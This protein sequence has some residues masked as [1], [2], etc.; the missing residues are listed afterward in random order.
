MAEAKIV[1][2]SSWTKGVV[3]VS[4]RF[5]IPKGALP[6][7]VN[8]LL[9]ER[10]ALQVCDGSLRVSHVATPTGAWL[11][12]DRYTDFS[13]VTTKVGIM[14]VDATHVA[15]YDF[16]ADPAVI[17]VTTTPGSAS[18]M[19]NTSGWL[20]PQAFEF[21][22][23]LILTRGNGQKPQLFTSTGAGTFSDPADL[24]ATNAWQANHLYFYGDVVTDVANTHAF[25]C[26]GQF[27]GYIPNGGAGVAVG[28]IGPQGQ[29]AGLSGGSEP[30]WNFATGGGTFDNV[31]LWQTMANVARANNQA[32]IGAA[33][34]I[35]HLGA[36]WAWNTSPTNSSDGL[37]GPCVLRQSSVQNPNSWPMINVDYVGRDDGTSGTGMAVFTIAEAGIAP[38]ASL[39]LFKDYSTYQ[40]NGLFQTPGFSIQQAKTNMGCTAPRSALFA[41]GYGIFRLTHLGVAQFDGVK[42]TI[43]S[44]EIRPYLFGG[45][46]VAGMDQ[47]ND[48]NCRAALCVSPPLYLLAIPLASGTTN[49]YGIQGGDGALIRILCYDL[50]FKAWAV[51]DLPFKILSLNQLLIQGAT[52]PHHAVTT[53]AGGFSDGVIRNLQN[54]DT[55]FDN[56][57]APG[58]PTAIAWQ[59]ETPTIGSPTERNYFRRLNLRMHAP[60]A[61]TITIAPI[62]D[63]EAPPSITKGMSAAEPSQSGTYGTNIETVAQYEG[64]ADL[65]ATHSLDQNASSARAQISGSGKTTIEAVQWQ[66]RPKPPRPSA[67]Q[68]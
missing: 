66:V 54:G 30:P 36:L 57:L 37:D 56:P 65:M 6:L 23:D 10:G 28:P 5:S 2:Q 47:S 39:V 42:D 68:I 67:T 22:G 41:T 34:M 33:H 24:G 48:Q 38:Q 40:V 29:P 62:F 53:V 9:G 32:P 16:T 44:E 55:T 13:L 31:L 64:E 20:H 8:L 52:A 59:M 63:A 43:I 61:P 26:Y 4:N 21:A 17:L 25:L 35:Q 15:V 45:F 27:N 50:I 49:Y 58:S 7:L 1:T 19:S 14:Q 11:A 60:A 51:I 18:N 46:G 3:A 12:L